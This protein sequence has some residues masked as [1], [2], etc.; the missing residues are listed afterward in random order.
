MPN[1]KSSGND[2][3]TK[4]FYEEFWDDLKPPLPLSV[5]LK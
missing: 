3:I 4:E 2:G 5:H 1:N